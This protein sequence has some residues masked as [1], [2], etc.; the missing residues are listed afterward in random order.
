MRLIA[1]YYFRYSSSKMCALM[2]GSL[3]TWSE[4]GVVLRR[5]WSALRGVCVW[6]SRWSALCCWRR[7]R[8]TV[9]D[10]GTGQVLY[11]PSFASRLA[12]LLMSGLY[13]LNHFDCLVMCY[14]LFRL[15]TRVDARRRTIQY[16]ARRGQLSVHKLFTSCIRRCPV[17]RACD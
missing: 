8:G 11:T 5:A 10:I 6:L 17:S 15:R 9:F 7:V 13:C 14:A 2:A 12:Q 3:V 4:V 1:P 16:S